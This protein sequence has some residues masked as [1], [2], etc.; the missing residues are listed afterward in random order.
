MGFLGRTR[1]DPGLT[2][3]IAVLTE[4][5]RAL[6]AKISLLDEQ[7]STLQ[8]RHDEAVQSTEN[9]VHLLRNMEKFGQTLIGTQQTMA[10]MAQTL[11]QEKEEAQNAGAISAG[12]RDLMLRISRDLGNLSEHSRQTMTSVEGLNAN[13]GQIG[14]ILQLIKEI[15]SQTNLLALN[16]AIEAARAGEAGRGFAV[17]ADEVRKLAERTAKA[18]G[19]IDSLVG[20]IQRDTRE[21]QSG[22]EN[23]AGRADTF[24]SDGAKATE[25]LENVLGLSKKVE[26]AIALA[27]LRSFTELAKLDHTVFK[28]EVYKVFMG[29]SQK[30]EGDFANHTGCRLGKWYY[31][32]EG[33]HCFSKFDGYAAM[34]AP[35][36]AVH[37]HGREA[38]ARYF[39]GDFVGGSRFLDEM[40][41]ASQ[42]VIACLERMALCGESHPEILCVA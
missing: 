26:L 31:E 15:A 17:V 14:G 41:A 33:K 1:N 21:A 35:H 28:F 11:K 6:K 2:D 39:A 22:I 40:E 18:T 38:L 30:S 32:G 13:T 25:N 42:N 34:E 27:A 7:L 23:L 24:G 12:S 20:N 16:A 37:K 9:W 5:N 36:L 4:E 19:E 8:L 29:V 10:G 3:T